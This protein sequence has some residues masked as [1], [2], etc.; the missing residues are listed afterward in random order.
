V[1]H[2]RDFGR[3]EMNFGG[4]REDHILVVEKEILQEIE[5]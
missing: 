4:Q 5:N 1:Q 2:L 3:F